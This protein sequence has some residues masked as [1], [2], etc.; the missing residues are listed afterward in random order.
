MNAHKDISLDG[1]QISAA[2]AV[3][4]LV[5]DPTRLK[6]L[7]ALLHGEHAV[8]DLAAHVGVRQTAVS[9][10]LAKLRAAHIVKARR[11]GNKMYYLAENEHVHRMITEALHQADHINNGEDAVHGTT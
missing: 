7:W 5:S 9:Q 10:H 4:K 1:E 3:L 11:D 8:G 2:A 6:I